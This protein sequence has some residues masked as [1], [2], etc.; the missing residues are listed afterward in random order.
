MT[1][2]LETEIRSDA[3]TVE[4][5]KAISEASNSLSDGFR[6]WGA[7]E[8]GLFRRKPFLEIPE[9]HNYLTDAADWNATTWDFEPEGRARLSRTLNWLYEQLPEAFSF[10]A[11][12][13]PVTTEE[14]EIGRAELLDLVQNNA[15]STGTLYRVRAA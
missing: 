3:L 8:V 9:L 12:W 7:W 11:T 13:G 4:R 10:K 15:V 14:R 5:G 2:D 1:P 6:V